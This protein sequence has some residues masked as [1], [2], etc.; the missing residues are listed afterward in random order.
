MTRVGLDPTPDLQVALGKGYMRVVELVLFLV[1]L[2]CMEGG[3]DT[4]SYPQGLN[5]HQCPPDSFLVI[6]LCDSFV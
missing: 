1:T 2:P 5:G 3:C 6:C 4:V